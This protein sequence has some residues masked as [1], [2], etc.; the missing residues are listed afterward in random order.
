[1]STAALAIRN[2]AYQRLDGWPGFNSF[3]LTP[4]GTAQPDRLPSLAVYLSG[5]TMRPDGDANA[6]EPKFLSDVTI[7]IA[8]MRKAGD[9]A[10]L[11]G[12]LDADVDELEA[13]LL[14]DTTFVHFGGQFKAPTGETWS[15]GQAIYW[16]PLL[17][18]A[19]ADPNGNMLLGMVEGVVNESAGVWR[20]GEL[21]E[22]ITGISRRHYW[23]NNGDTFFAEV[24][25]EL[26]FQVRV[27]FDPFVPD[28]Y[29]KTVIVT[30]PLNNDPNS[31]TLTTVID[32]AE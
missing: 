20:I 21:F 6:A 29:R 27:S 10:V 7:G 11:E 23:P 5:E 8:V 28:D 16:N 15:T 13:A 30:Q 19:T 4:M 25:L 31:P 22:A 2:A 12:Q 32:L 17:K 18:R 9:Q 1:M 14:S 26:T 24:R 3:A